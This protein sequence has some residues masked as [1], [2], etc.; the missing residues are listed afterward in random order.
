MYGRPAFLKAT[1]AEIRICDRD[2]KLICT[3][4]RSY[5]T[6]PRYITKSEHMPFEHRYYREVN[7]QDGN[8]CRQRAK[9]F[10]PNTA[11]MIDTALLSSQHEEQSYNS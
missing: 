11:K 8:Y 9:S 7:E 2:N 10:W 3:H 4:R 6:F 1:M 5:T